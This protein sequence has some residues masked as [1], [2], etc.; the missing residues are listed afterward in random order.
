[1]GKEAAI[2]RFY[3]RSKIL[4]ANSP[5]VFLVGSMLGGCMRKESTPHLPKQH[6]VVSL[7]SAAADSIRQTIR[8]NNLGSQM[9]LR[10]GVIK[11]E[12]DSFQYTMDF[13]SRPDAANDFLSE[14]EG[15]RIVVDKKSSAVL[16]GTVIDYEST[17][18]PG[19]RYRNPSAEPGNQ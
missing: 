6:A 1:M 15:I 18:T 16:Q 12:S 19:F 17:P 3:S 5:L 4:L 7:T 2:M 11:R 9:C 10:I 13:T 8:L 14:S